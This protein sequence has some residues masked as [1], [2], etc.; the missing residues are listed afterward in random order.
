[1]LTDDACASTPTSSS[2]P[3]PTPRR[4]ARSRTPTGACSACAPAIGA[5]AAAR[6]PAPACARAGRSSP[7]SPRR[8]GLDLGVLDRRRWPPQQLFAAVPFYAGLTLDEIGGR[9]VRWPE[10]DGRGAGLASP[11]R[12]RRVAEPPRPAAAPTARCASAPSARSGPPRGRG[13]ARAAV[14]ARPPGRRA[15]ARRRRARS[16]SARATASRSAPTA[17]ACRARSRCAP[18]CPPGTVFLA[19][20]VA[21][22]P[23]NVLTEPLV[24]CAASPG[25]PRPSRRRARAG[26]AGRRGPGRDAA[27]G[28]AADPAAGADMTPFAEVGYYE[29]WWIQILKAVVIFAVV[30]QLVPIVLLA[31]RKL[32]GRFQHRYGPNRVGPFGDP[33]AD[34][35][36]RQADHQGAVP[37]A[38][39]GRLAVRARA[40]DLDADRGRDVRD[41]P[42][43]RHGRHLRHAR[44]GSTASTRRSGSCT[45][46]PSAR[47]PSTG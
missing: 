43:R 39:V 27:V 21:D 7:T 10:R 35:R 17:R 4:T 23:A 16:A 19:E 36:H 3:R 12:A 25:R 22:A 42:V 8:A 46:S 28:A 1:M 26:R 32:L 5:P 41:H 34:G 33:A 6:L 24:R 14:P 29:A 11:P 44:S 15:V 9:G 47:S 37:A 45:R 13:L 40:R 18:P 38:H 2:P 31:E 30:F 20:G